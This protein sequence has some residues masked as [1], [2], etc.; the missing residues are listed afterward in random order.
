MTIEPLSLKELF[1]RAPVS[2]FL[3]HV[4]AFAAGYYAS[5]WLIKLEEKIRRIWK[6]KP[7]SYPGQAVCEKCRQCWCVCGGKRS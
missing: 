2:F 5:K 4:G 3:V 7:V 1:Q 6:K